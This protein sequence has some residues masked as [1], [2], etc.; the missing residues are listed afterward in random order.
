LSCFSK[1]KSSHRRCHRMVW[2][3]VEHRRWMLTAFMW[4]QGVRSRKD[5]NWTETIEGELCNFGQF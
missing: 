4:G 1:N 5:P 3:I 2:R